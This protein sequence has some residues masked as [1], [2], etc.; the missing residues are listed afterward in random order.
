LKVEQTW[1][2]NRK[3]KAEAGWQGSDS[4]HCTPAP[5]F[6]PSVVIPGMNS[7]PQPGT[8]KNLVS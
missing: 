5:V 6:A 3:V 1:R 2:T 8:I 7:I 4:Q